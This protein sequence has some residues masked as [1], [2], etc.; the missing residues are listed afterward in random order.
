[1]SA[2]PPAFQVFVAWLARAAFAVGVVAVIALSLMPSSAAPDT[3]INDKIGHFLAY[4]AL[5]LAGVTGFH[6][7]RAQVMIVCGLI[8]IGVLMEVGQLFA[9]GRQASVLDIIA[10]TLGVMCGTAVASAGLRMLDVLRPLVKA[11]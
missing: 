4:F 8:A 10:N 2:P 9:P 3:G 7:R 1:L 6:G 5:A 11:R